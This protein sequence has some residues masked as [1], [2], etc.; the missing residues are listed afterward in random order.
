MGRTGRLGRGAVPRRTPT[1]GHQRRIVKLRLAAPLGASADRVP[2]RVC[3]PSTVHKVLARHKL[4]RL[5]WLD[6]PAGRSIRRYE[7]A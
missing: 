3:I 4:A 6:R 2:P 5:D 1:G 7:H